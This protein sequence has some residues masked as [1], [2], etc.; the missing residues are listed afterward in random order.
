MS[1]SIRKSV[2]IS[3]DGFLKSMK[4]FFATKNIKLFEEMT[5]LVP[6]NEE[7]LHKM[8]LGELQQHISNQSIF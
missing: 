4:D 1:T 8:R 5:F 2:K 6:G 7:T 3:D